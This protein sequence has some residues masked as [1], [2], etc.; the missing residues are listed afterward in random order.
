MKRLNRQITTAFYKEAA[1]FAALQAHWSRLQ[2]DPVRRNTL[3]AAH[4]LLYQI[5]RGKNWQT[6]FTR[7][8]NPVK[9]ENGGFYS[10]GARRALLGLHSAVFAE[11]L[12]APFAEF[13]SPEA[14]CLIRE[15]IPPLDWNADPLEREPYRD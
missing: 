6:A 12:L 13:L 8:T 5:L 1:G 3:T 14:L 11:C 15:R 10:W 9:L 7:M 2:Q 4:H